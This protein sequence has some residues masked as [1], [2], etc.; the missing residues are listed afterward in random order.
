[1]R[2]HPKNWQEFQHYKD[3]NPAWIKLH[4]RLLDDFAFQRLPVASRALAPMLWLLASEASDGVID[5]TMEEIAFRLR[6]TEQDL[7]EA[8]KPLLESEFFNLEHDASAMLAE[9]YPREERETEEEIEK[10]NPSDCQKDRPQVAS[11]TR[12]QNSVPMPES[13]PDSAAKANAIAYWRQHGRADQFDVDIE[14]DA[15]IAHNLKN[16]AT[17]RDWNGAWRTWYVNAVKFAKERPRPRY[18][19]GVTPMASPAGG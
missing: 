3:R 4:K 1:M 6:M 18:S 14:A 7:S 5:A 13:F 9:V 12:R 11:R 10:T 16:A 19:G 2:I 8:I 15:F 17:Y